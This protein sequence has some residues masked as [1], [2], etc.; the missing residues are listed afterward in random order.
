MKPRFVADNRAALDEVAAATSRC[1]AVVGFVEAIGELATSRRTARRR[2]RDPASGTTGQR[3]RDLRRRR[4]SSAT[5]HKRILPNYG[6]FDEQRWFV[7][8]HRSLRALRDRRGWRSGVSICEDVWSPDGPVVA[9][10]RGGADLVVNINASPYSHGRWD[11]RLAMLRRAGRPRPGCALAYCNLVGGQDELVFDGA[12]VVLGSRRL[13]A[14][15]GSHSSPRTCWWSTSWR[16]GQRVAA[17]HAVGRGGEPAGRRSES[18]RSGRPSARPSPRAPRSTRPLSSA[19][20]TTCGRTGSATPSSGCR[21]ASTRRWW[22]RSPPTRSGAEHVHALSMPSRYS[23]A[24]SVDDALDLA[25]RLG[26]DV[27]VV[28]IDPAHQALADRADPGARRR[29]AGA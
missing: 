23:S 13:A 2:R 14:R 6:V 1:V 18:P 15:R 4:R 9:L 25:G 10:G 26:I 16:A 28:P 27:R 7:P 24:G 8:G 5:Y 19:P 20:A 11:E 17:P 12:S 29:A 22:R 3:R 21:A